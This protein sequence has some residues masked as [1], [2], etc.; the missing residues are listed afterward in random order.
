M[1]SDYRM[2]CFPQAVVAFVVARLPRTL[3]LDA[4]L[5]DCPQPL[6]GF[7][8]CVF[9]PFRPLIENCDVVCVF[10]CFV[11]G[12]GKR[13]EDDNGEDEEQDKEEGQVRVRQQLFSSRQCQYSISRQHWMRGD[14][15]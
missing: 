6:E 13:T 8:F 4:A 11:Q 10:V 3:A 5:W 7:C 1:G 15:S 14:S 12:D 9:F 2:F